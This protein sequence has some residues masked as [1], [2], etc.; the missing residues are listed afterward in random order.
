MWSDLWSPLSLFVV[1]RRRRPKTDQ[2]S[3]PISVLMWL[4]S[5]RARQALHEVIE[6]PVKKF[7]RS[8][9]RPRYI[10]FGLARHGR[11][12]GE[13][14]YSPNR[15]SAILPSTAWFGLPPVRYMLPA[16]LVLS[17][18]AFQLPKSRESRPRHVPRS[19]NACLHVQAFPGFPCLRREYL[20]AAMGRGADYRE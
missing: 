10:S 19:M 16:I 2:T 14:G 15:Y 9:R 18:Q 3:S 17:P 13:E 8:L 6:K 12:S 7:A 5:P 4:P 20:P 1:D 11:A